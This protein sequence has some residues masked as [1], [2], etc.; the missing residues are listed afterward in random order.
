M[1]GGAAR[2]WS[3]MIYE[4]MNL[5]WYLHLNFWSAWH[6]YVGSWLKRVG[7][8]DR[9]NQA[10]RSHSS[11][12]FSEFPNKERGETG[13]FSSGIFFGLSWNIIRTL[14]IPTIWVLLP[15]INMPFLNSKA[16][17][18]VAEPPSYPLLMH[19]A[20]LSLHADFG[21]L[22]VWLH[23]RFLHT[24]ISFYL[25]NYLYFLFIWYS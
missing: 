11:A 4:S 5:R 24:Y 20:G 15:K 18:M 23:D 8:S 3:S 9:P 12:S 6:M 10:S 21:F 1:L 7:M 22:V 19:S 17:A 14:I 13:E 25:F 2:P 16:A